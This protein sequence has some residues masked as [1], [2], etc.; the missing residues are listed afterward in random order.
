MLTCPCLEGLRLMCGGATE[1]GGCVSALVAEAM[2]KNGDL[3]WL[4]LASHLT[5]V[6]TVTSYSDC[7][8]LSNQEF[9]G[10][11]TEDE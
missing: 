2:V 1:K 7:D 9:E 3:W 10:E 11:A 8:R 6:F 5:A 4:L